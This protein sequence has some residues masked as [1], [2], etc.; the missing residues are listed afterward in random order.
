MATTW[1]PH[2][3]ANCKAKWP[4]PPMPT[5]PIRSVG[6]SFVSVHGCKNG[7]SSTHERPSVFWFNAVRD[8]VAESGVKHGVACK[9]SKP[10]R[11]DGTMSTHDLIGRSTLFTIKT[12][13]FE[14]SKAR[15]EYCGVNKRSIVLA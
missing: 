10:S 2:A 3:C 9:P 6:L 5:I 15:Q 14:I 8:L 13:G 7:G 1:H 11:K 12:R 4:K